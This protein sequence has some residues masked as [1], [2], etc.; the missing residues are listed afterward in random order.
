MPGAGG[1][2]K[3]HAL[4]IDPHPSRGAN[5]KNQ[6]RGHTAPP[7]CPHQRHPYD[8]L[9]V[10]TGGPTRYAIER[11][12]TTNRGNRKYHENYPHP[13]G[14]WPTAQSRLPSPAASSHA[15]QSRAPPMKI[16]IENS[17]TKP[18]HPKTVQCTNRVSA[19]HLYLGPAARIN[20]YHTA[21]SPATLHLGP[22]TATRPHEA[23]VKTV[24]ETTRGVYCLGP[25]LWHRGR[26]SNLGLGIAR[27]PSSPTRL[28]RAPGAQ[29]TPCENPT[30][31][32]RCTY[33]TPGC[34]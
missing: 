28:G 4:A 13:K 10:R 7:R 30:R 32:T 8:I 23:G 34:S 1:N 14:R 16:K 15:H 22:N 3:K 20:K 6:A 26:E 5:P 27:S 19:S 31:T 12:T 24:P 21:S 2:L 17:P 18:A 29:A 9:R 11:Y 25:P 33:T